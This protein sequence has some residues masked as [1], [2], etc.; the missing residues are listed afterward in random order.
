[1]GKIEGHYKIF[2]LQNW[3]TLV[4]DIK[5][6]FKVHWT[7]SRDNKC[8]K[9]NAV[10]L[11]LNG[12]GKNGRKGGGVPTPAF[13]PVRGVKLG[14]K[15]LNSMLETPVCGVALQHSTHRPGLGARTKEN[16]YRMGVMNMR[17]AHL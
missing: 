7:K 15:R 3:R 2:F 12:C 4:N 11:K 13:H 14:Q 9:E 16:T 6:S 17:M 8:H 1:M 10:N 5:C